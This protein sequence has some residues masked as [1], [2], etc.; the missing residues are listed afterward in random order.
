LLVFLQIT[1]GGV[2]HSNYI[3]PLINEIFIAAAE[4]K[5]NYGAKTLVVTGTH[6]IPCA[7][8][9]ETAIK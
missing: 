6:K 9:S 3:V 8:G 5:S 2:E 1:L 7:A 4:S